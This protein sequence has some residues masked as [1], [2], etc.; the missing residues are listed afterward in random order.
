MGK[1]EVQIEVGDTLQNGDY[2]AKVVELSDEVVSTSDGA[3]TYRFSVECRIER[4]DVALIK[5]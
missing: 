1:K 4:G 2:T 3:D 5:A